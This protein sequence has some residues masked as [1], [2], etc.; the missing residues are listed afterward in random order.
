MTHTSPPSVTPKAL[1][2]T[3]FVIGGYAIEVLFCPD[4][5]VDRLED[6]LPRPGYMCLI[7]QSERTEG[8]FQVN[9]KQLNGS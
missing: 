8:V 1:P 3:R 7:H 9:V 2:S 4:A 5:S 6:V